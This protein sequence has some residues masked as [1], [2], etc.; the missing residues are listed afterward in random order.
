M[1]KFL[2]I[3]IALAA[4]VLVA[5]AG[6]GVID[7][8][9]RLAGHPA[10]GT[11]VQ[12]TVESALASLP[13][14]ATTEDYWNVLNLQFV[15][16]ACLQQVKKT[17]GSNAWAVFSCTCNEDATPTLKSY[18]CRVSTAAGTKSLTAACNKQRS[19]CAIEGEGQRAELSFEQIINAAR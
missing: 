5:A 3:L 19:I 4:V 14:N 9:P 1:N 2:I 17:A 16:A 15:E 18:S 8:A 10:G 7:L 11:Q 13:A 12:E 6:F